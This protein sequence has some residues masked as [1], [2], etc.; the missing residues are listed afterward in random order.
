M[1]NPG[2]VKV[3]FGTIRKILS[4]VQAPACSTDCEVFDNNFLGTVTYMSYNG[5]LEIGEK[6]PR[7]L[8]RLSGK[9]RLE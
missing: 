8:R 3:V 1:N 4:N 2:P 6:L 9:E 5:K 7:K